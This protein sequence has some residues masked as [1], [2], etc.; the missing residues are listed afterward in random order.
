MS[1]FKTIWRLLTFRL[2]RDQFLR[3]DRPHFF[4]G[5]IGT[6]LAGVG[7]YWD[8]PN[9]SLLQHAGIGSVVYIFLLSAFIWLIVLPFRV[10]KWNYGIVLTFV[11]LT[12]FPAILYAI[13]VEKFMTLATANAVNGWFLTIIAIWRL[14]LLFFFLKRYTGLY[15]I[16]TI[17]LMPICVIVTVLS[18]LNL[19]N[20]VFEIMGGFRNPSANDSSFTIVM[21]LS[22]VSI[23]ASVPLLILYIAAIVERHKEIRQKQPSK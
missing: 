13:P 20:V 4:A 16:W 17:T 5:L 19:Q 18:V 1:I 9:A 11:S 22:W 14:A 8:D 15:D 10:E 3:F 2:T 23:L 7:R 6:W 21:L 12:S